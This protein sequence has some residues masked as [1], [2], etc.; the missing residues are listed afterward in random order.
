MKQ[1]GSLISILQKSSLE[2][3]QLVQR[4][5]AWTSVSPFAAT[6]SDTHPH[7]HTAFASGTGIDSGLDW[8]AA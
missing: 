3:K 5:P 4:Y 1:P 2:V 8:P 7:T 6:P